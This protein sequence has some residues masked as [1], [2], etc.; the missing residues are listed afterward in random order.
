MRTPLLLRLAGLL[1]AL[2]LVAG[3]APSSHAGRAPARL[4]PVHVKIQNFAFSPTPVTIA[5]GRTVVWTNRDVLFGH[6][7]VVVRG[8]RFFRSPLI[9]P[10]E[11]FSHTFRVAGRYVYKCGVHPFMRGVVV[12][13]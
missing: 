12:V 4:A 8:P 13:R 2:G 1:L 10:G 7:V 3:A 5:K 11:T 9:R 6:T